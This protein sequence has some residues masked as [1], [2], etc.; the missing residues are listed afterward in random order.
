MIY[1]NETSVSFHR[2]VLNDHFFSG[3]HV[4]ALQRNPEIMVAQS[5]VMQLP[6]GYD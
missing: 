4:T 1:R 2:E 6:S 3:S 5:L